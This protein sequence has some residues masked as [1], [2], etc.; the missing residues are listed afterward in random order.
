MLLLCQLFPLSMQTNIYTHLKE[1]S[2]KSLRGNTISQI[3]RLWDICSPFHTVVNVIYHTI[4]I[5]SKTET[6]H[7]KLECGC[8]LI[9]PDVI[10]F[11]IGYLILKSRD[12]NRKWRILGKS[13]QVGHFSCFTMFFLSW[14][15]Y[16]L[17]VMFV[18]I[19]WL[20]T[21]IIIFKKIL[22]HL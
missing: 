18:R 21:Q 12:K 19:R 20:L 16:C 9:S 11:M 14:R 17:L 10:S 4:K 5:A 2:L 22:D 6:A 3:G 7:K 13:C 1:K 15:C 8:G